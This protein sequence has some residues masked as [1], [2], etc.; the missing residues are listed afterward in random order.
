MSERARIVDLL[1]RVHNGDAWHGPSVMDAL[2][3]VTAAQARAR[4]IE[5]AHSIWETA[6]HMIAWRHEVRER[7]HGGTPSL[8]EP[9]D[10]PPVPDED[11]KWNEVAT[12]MD[13][14]HRLL[15]VAVESLSDAELE[16]R[17]GPSRQPGL[18]TGVS[19]AVMLHGIVHHDAYHAGQINLL[20]KAG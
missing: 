20:K 10:W 7:L 5:G 13:V 14:S 19:V 17:V 8:P 2:E 3:G 12:L 16:R 15:V 9:G 18:G 6:L 4:P 1:R 11:A